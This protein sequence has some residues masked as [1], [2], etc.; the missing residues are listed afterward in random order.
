MRFKI[1]AESTDFYSENFT[2]LYVLRK[3]QNLNYIGNKMVRPI[4]RILN[5]IGLTKNAGFLRFLEPFG[6]LIFVCRKV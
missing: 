5:K 2:R 3:V 1:L 4:A 6:V